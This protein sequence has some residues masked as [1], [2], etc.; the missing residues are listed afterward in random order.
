MCIMMICSEFTYAFTLLIKAFAASKFR[1]NAITSSVIKHFVVCTLTWPAK[2][3]PAMSAFNACKIFSVM[4]GVT[5]FN[6][7]HGMLCSDN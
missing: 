5:P 4:Q 7:D 2:V 1:R 6:D 3:D